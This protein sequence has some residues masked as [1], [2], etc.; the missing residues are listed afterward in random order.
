MPASISSCAGAARTWI[1]YSTRVT[2]GST[3][4]SPARF[5]RLSGWLW[6]PGVSFSIYGERGIIDI[7]AFHAERGIVLVIEIKTAIVEVQDLVGGVDRKRRLA[8]RIARE[9]GW[10]AGVV[11]CWVVV[12]DTR[13][14]RR[15]VLEH[16]AML[17]AA[18]PA[19]GRSLGRWLRDPVGPIAALTFVT[20]EQA[21]HASRVL[22][23][24]RRVRRPD[25]TS[26]KGM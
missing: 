18:F 20:E 6:S 3:N 14:N 2:R 16:R 21:A 11:G 12:A 26:G 8:N 15:R 23:A 25:R 22:S 10:Q 13:T 7:L 4:S 1:N 5:G 17:R 24:R 9:R 19:E